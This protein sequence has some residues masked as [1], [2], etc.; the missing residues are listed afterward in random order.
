MK[1]YIDYVNPLN[2]IFSNSDNI[3]LL[4]FFFS[5]RFFFFKFY[6]VSG[7]YIFRIRNE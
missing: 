6:L 1:E 4:S 7:K 3:S 5:F 2:D